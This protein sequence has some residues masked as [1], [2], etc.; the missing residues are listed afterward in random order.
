MSSTRAPLV[1]YIALAVVAVVL[2]HAAAT[3]HSPSYADRTSWQ[4]VSTRIG[5]GSDG[6]PV[7]W[8]GRKGNDTTIDTH[9]SKVSPDKHATYRT[10]QS[11]SQGAT[12][13][14]NGAFVILARNSDVWEII[15]SIRGMEGKLR[16]VLAHSSA[17]VD[18]HGRV[19]IGSTTSTTTLTYF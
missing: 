10:E 12:D 5:L 14:A 1:R 2:I 4:A 9:T 13:K 6:T 16:E 17:R 7:S 15:E 18:F 11:A 3:F 19:Q 8:L